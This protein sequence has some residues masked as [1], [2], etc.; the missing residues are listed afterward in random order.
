MLEKSKLKYLLQNWKQGIHLIFRT[1]RFGVN[2]KWWSQ[3]D[4]VMGVGIYQIFFDCVRIWPLFR[5]YQFIK[6]RAINL[7]F[8]TAE[9]CCILWKK[10]I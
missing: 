6:F 1:K 4:S 3:F 2:N 9:Q 7:G 10:E 5:N 8:L